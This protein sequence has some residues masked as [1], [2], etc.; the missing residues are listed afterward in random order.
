MYQPR[1]YRDWIK[2]ADLVST[3]IAVKE[4]DLHIRACRSLT[5]ESLKSVHRHRA[6]LELYIAENPVFLTSLIPVIAS[7]NAPDI[8]KEMISAS[9]KAGVG[10]MAAVAGAIAESVG[11]DLLKYSDE[12]IVENG[13]DIY[14][15]LLQ[16]RKVGIYAGDSPYTGNIALEVLPDETPLGLCTS[17]GTVGHSLSFGNADAVVILGHSTA[18]ADAVATATGNIIKISSDIPSGIDFAKSIEGITGVLIIQGKD[19]G[20][21]GNIKLV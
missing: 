16:K 14:L 15:K 11:E 19:L 12:I 9:A 1:I 7:T 18:L 21:W 8:I 3:V 2:D 13:G 5:E 4:T 10:P 17:S 6:F 20:A